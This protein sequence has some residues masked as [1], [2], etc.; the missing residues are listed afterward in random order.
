MGNPAAACGSLG[1]HAPESQINSLAAGVEIDD[2]P[3]VNYFFAAHL[4]YCGQDAAALRM[5]RLAIDHNDCSY[6]VTDK[7]PF[8]D[9]LRAPPAFAK[10][11][12]AGIACHQNFVT[13]REQRSKVIARETPLSPG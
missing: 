13:N 2:D 5:L 1:Q 8:F 3:E 12:A 4:A 9:K 10:V 7:D 6:P 11:R